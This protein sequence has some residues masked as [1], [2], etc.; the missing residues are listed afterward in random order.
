MKEQEIKYEC[1]DTLALLCLFSRLGAS[2]PHNVFV[3]FLSL[4]ITM[5]FL[6]VIVT[7]AVGSGGGG[8]AA[9]SCVLSILRVL[10]AF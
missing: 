6:F 7:V 9:V 4:I 3:L 2:M 10:I 8:A 5:L 1:A